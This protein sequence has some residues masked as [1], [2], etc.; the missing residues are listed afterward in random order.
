M[1]E[2]IGLNYWTLSCEPER[3]LLLITGHYPADTF[4]L[5]MIMS[6]N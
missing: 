6:S 4:L 2:V 1:R 5:H 3:T